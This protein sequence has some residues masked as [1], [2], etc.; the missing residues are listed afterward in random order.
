V[1]VEDIKLEAPKTKSFT[2]ALKKLN[3][4]GKKILLVLGEYDDNLH[5]SVRNVP[6]IESTMLA[7]INTYDIV[8]ADVLVISESAARVF[9]SEGEEVNA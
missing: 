8:N 1:V 7:D 6:T 2:D 4:G 9:A 3:V 5:L